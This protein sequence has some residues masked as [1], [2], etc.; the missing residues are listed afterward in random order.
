MSSLP[1][2]VSVL[3]GVYLAAYCFTW[4]EDTLAWYSYISCPFPL[5]LWCAEVTSVHWVKQ[6]FINSSVLHFL[7]LWRH[8]SNVSIQ[9]ANCYWHVSFVLFSFSKDQWHYLCVLLL[10][11]LTDI[12]TALIRHCRDADRDWT[13]L[14]E[15]GGG[16]QSWW[17]YFLTAA[18]SPIR[19]LALTSD[20]KF[21][22]KNIRAK[23]LDGAS[24]FSRALLRQCFISA[25]SFAVFPFF[26][27]IGYLTM[28]C[29]RLLDR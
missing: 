7:F 2:F 27:A 3:L 24:V 6:S 22:K 4:C 5:L 9:S 18:S 21:K 19:R 23:N 20:R 10:L 16:V 15:R 11:L 12:A 13:N 25:V 26:Q 29:I 8:C 14:N 28:T 17:V 1:S